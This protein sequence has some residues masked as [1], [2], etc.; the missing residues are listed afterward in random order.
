MQMKLKAV[1]EI[2]INDHHIRPISVIRKFSNQKASGRPPN[3]S[4]ILGVMPQPQVQVSVIF[5]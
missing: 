5:S 3:S 4:G 1:V 2:L